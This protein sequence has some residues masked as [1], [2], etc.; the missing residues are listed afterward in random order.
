MKSYVRLDIADVAKALAHENDEL[1]AEFINEFSRELKVYNKDSKLEGLQPCNI[2]DKL[3][4]NGI[5]LIE[6]LY[7]FIKL[8]KQ[9]EPKGKGQ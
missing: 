8:R 3:N 6:S 7:E 9:T 1:Q 4:E 5:D 2:S